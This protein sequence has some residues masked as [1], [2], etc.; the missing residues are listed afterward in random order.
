MTMGIFLL[1]FPFILCIGTIRPLKRGGR[2]C[3]GTAKYAFV[4]LGEEQRIL[5]GVFCCKRRKWVRN[6]VRA[7]RGPSRTG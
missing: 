7:E 5:P 3:G 1:F 4:R 2:I 6:E